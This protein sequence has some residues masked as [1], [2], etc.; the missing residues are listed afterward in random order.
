MQYTPAQGMPPLYFVRH[1]ATAANAA[2][3]RCGGDLDLPLTEPGRQQ[4]LDAAAQVCALRPRVGLVISSDLKRTRETAA[5]L[6]AALGGVPMLVVP[7]FGERRLGDWNLRPIAETQAWLA[8]G[9]TPPGGE[10]E[11]DFVARI[12]LAVA[13]IAAHRAAHPLVVGSKGVARVLALLEG[14]A[15]RLDLGNAEFVSFQLPAAP[16]APA[17]AVTAPCCAASGD[18]P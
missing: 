5:I 15:Q 1:G 11:A 2:G 3:L 6:A 12:A 14:R 18:Q 4:A 9:Q 10:A 17:Q 16:A 13:S 7:G 8:S